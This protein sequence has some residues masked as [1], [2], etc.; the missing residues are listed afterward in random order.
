MALR[1][2]DLAEKALD[3]GAQPAGFSSKLAAGIEHGIGDLTGFGGGVGNLCSTASAA[4]QGA[5]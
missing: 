2:A 4:R 5:L 1:D 3:F